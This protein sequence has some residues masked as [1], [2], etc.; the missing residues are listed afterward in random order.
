MVPVDCGVVLVAVLDVT[1]VVAVVSGAVEADGAALGPG[2]ASLVEQA[3]RATMASAEAPM[4]TR[5]RL[6]T[7]DSIT[8]DLK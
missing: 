1:V 6:T 7:S 4:T 5:R 3:P 2:G 8:T